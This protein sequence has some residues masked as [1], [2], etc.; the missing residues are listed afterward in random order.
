MSGVAIIKK[1]EKCEAWWRMPLIPILGKQ[2][3]ANLSLK[4]AWPTEQET[5]RN[6][7][8]EEKKKGKKPN[9]QKSQR[10]CVSS[11]MEMLVTSAT[12]EVEI[13]F[14]QEPEELPC[15]P[16]LLFLGT[17]LKESRPASHGDTTVSGRQAWNQRH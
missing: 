13:A 1:T 12:V 10:G 16:A 8:S 14:P 7:D 6:P 4:S 2:R 9:E 3:Q 15:D 17:H 11:L 5:Q